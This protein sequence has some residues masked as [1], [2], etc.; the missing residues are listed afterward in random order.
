MPS[1]SRKPGGQESIDLL[2]STP[3]ASQSSRSVP[4][5]FC[6]T[7]LASTTGGTAFVRASDEIKNLCLLHET[8]ILERR[9]FSLFNVGINHFARVAN[10]KTIS[11]SPEPIAIY[12]GQ[13]MVCH[14]FL[15]KNPLA[16]LR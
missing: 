6:S 13:Q 5:G 3:T 4:S 7:S 16:V 10:Q 9:V 12:F 14:L 8:E 11:H 1:V 15:K 2:N